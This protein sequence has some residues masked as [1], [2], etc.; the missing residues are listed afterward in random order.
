MKT[1]EAMNRLADKDCLDKIY[2]FS[3]Q[4]CNTSQEAEDLCSEIVLEV[5]SAL[6]KQK[7]VQN[8]YAFIWTIARRVY[9]DFCRTQNLKKSYFDFANFDSC[10]VKIACSEDEITELIE[11]EEKSERI[12]KIYEEIAFLSKGFRQVMVMYYIE[13][14][15]VKKISELLN[16]SE[17][18]VKQRL[19]SAR[20]TIR[21][22]VEIMKERTSLT[23]NPIRL[24]GWSRSDATSKSKGSMWGLI[25]RELSQNL[26]YL[27][28]EKPKT[29]RELAEML[30][31]PMPYV[32][33]ELEIQCAG[34]DDEYG[35]MR[36]L[37]NGRYVTNIHVVDYT[38]FEQAADIY[39]KH[40]PEF[41]QIIKTNVEVN[42]KRILSI[43]YLNGK[44]DLSTLLSF[45]IPN[46][47]VYILDRVAWALE[48]YMAPI[49]PLQREYTCAYV[50]FAD[51]QEPDLEFYSQASALSG[52]IE[53]FKSVLIYNPYGKWLNQRIEKG[54]DITRDEKLKLTL[55]SIGGIS[56]KQLS[57]EEK[58]TA[59]K[60]IACG[61]MC[62]RKEQL[63]PGIIVIDK[64]NEQKFYK[65]FID[66]TKNM[67][68]V[69]EKIAEELGNFM[70]QHVPK[71]LINEYPAYAKLIAGWRMVS[72][73]VDRCVDGGMLPSKKEESANGMLMIV[74]E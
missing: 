55:R 45:L 56:E 17:T 74:E 32:E 60:A 23:L 26:I 36:K 59:A 48:S 19:F 27:C 35:T 33:D 44:N 9:A 61:Y 72:K 68:P 40:L 65:C 7:N 12:E 29:A 62:K 41:Y 22:E 57:E 6:Q 18:T 14:L 53:R 3:Y 67:K 54:H 37:K 30:H 52:P 47:A 58:E 24:V 70:K 1:N 38:E 43:P 5:I 11:Q 39:E 31:V 20:N 66:L 2:G 64:K 69:I 71:H 28:K 21:R 13:G 8:F 16:I 42:E 50:A 10:C 63:E 34:G 15:R 73:I 46:M 49:E 4:R 51:N 25:E